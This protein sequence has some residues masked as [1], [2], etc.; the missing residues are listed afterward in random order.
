MQEVGTDRTIGHSG[1][2]LPPP[3]P[4]RLFARGGA[5]ARW[6]HV[7]AR[8][9]AAA[10]PVPR[11]VPGARG[12]APGGARVCA[13]ARGAHVA[14]GC[15][16]DQGA[17]VA[18]RGQHRGAARPRLARDCGSGVARGCG[19]GRAGVQGAPCC[20]VR[21]RVVEGFVG[22]CAVG[23]FVRSCVDMLVLRADDGQWTEL[24]VRQRKAKL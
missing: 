14:D 17:P 8:R 5:A 23:E 6:G 2:E 21:G 3:A 16:V 4:A 1:V 19:G 10:G 18:R 12:G 11:D 20:A 13:R 9:A 7:R 22:V 24:D 15:R